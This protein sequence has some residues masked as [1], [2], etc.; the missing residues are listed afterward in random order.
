MAH[1]GLHFIPDI[2][3]IRRVFVTVFHKT[4]KRV[5][6]A[7][8]AGMES[9]T[10]RLIE[11]GVGKAV[12]YVDIDGHF[13]CGADKTGGGLFDLAVALAGN[14]SA[15]ERLKISFEL[16]HVY[17]FRR[18]SSGVLIKLT[19][20]LAFLL[21]TEVIVPYENRFVNIPF[22]FF[23]QDFHGAIFPSGNGRGT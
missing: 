13:L 12:F 23:L 17:S 5:E 2:L 11:T 16:M 19:E 1:I 7:V 10:G 15:S 6:I 18:K 22:I 3:Q 21:C 8:S 9:H 4:V 20:K 14:K